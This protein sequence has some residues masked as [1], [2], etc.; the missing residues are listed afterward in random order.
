[1]LYINGSLLLAFTYSF[2]SPKYVYESE[3]KK[4]LHKHQIYRIKFVIKTIKG[5]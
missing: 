4:S 2:F 1:M 5:T 3:E